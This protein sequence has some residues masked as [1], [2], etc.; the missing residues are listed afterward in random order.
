M[1]Y[2]NTEKKLSDTNGRNLSIYRTLNK[3]FPN[4][5]QL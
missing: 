3:H 4:V 2:N 5:D 1:K